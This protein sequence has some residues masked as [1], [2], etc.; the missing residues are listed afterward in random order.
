VV[1]VHLSLRSN[2]RAVAP[3]L[4]EIL[5]V[6]IVV[7][8]SATLWF[9]FNG[10]FTTAT[11]SHTVVGMHDNGFVAAT[12]PDYCCLN[13]TIIEITF[14]SGGARSWE[15][16]VQFVVESGNDSAVMVQGDLFEAA[17]DRA[18]YYIGIY[19]GSADEASIANIGYNDFNGDG[20]ISA[21][22]RIE[23]RGMSKEF[24]GAS[25]V[26]VGGDNTLGTHI[27]P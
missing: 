12:T 2:R 3:V 1:R 9:T 23:M 5:M 25:I 8:M 14:A 18:F 4:A 10:I 15:S 22:D 24:H 27:L 11:D 26:L 7:V 16:G 17:H 21:G 20:Q 19:H 6:V 13:D